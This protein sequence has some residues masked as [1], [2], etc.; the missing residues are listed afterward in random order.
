VHLLRLALAG[1]ILVAMSGAI[2][3]LGDTLFPSR[4]LTDGFREDLARGAH[5]FVALRIWHP[6][7]AVLVGFFL[8]L[9]LASLR[10]RLPAGPD[11]SPA[12]RLATACFA[13]VAIQLAT[14]IVNLALLAP[15]PLQ[16]VHL[17]LA[18]LL[19]LG[20]VWLLASVSGADR[21]T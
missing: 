16:L 19:W 5:A 12:R 2:A 8:M 1:V 20:L 9:L 17:L 4:S 3:A 18:D 15:V 7:L 6:V 14:G 11:S 13:L 21:P 10:G